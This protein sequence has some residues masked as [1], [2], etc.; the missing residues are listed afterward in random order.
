MK[1]IT[2]NE[3]KDTRKCVVIPEYIEG[4][5]TERKRQSERKKIGF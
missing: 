4:I 3:R 1:E 2:M 5:P